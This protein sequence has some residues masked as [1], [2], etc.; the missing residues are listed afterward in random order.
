[1]P[2]DRIT[3]W[4]VTLPGL[5]IEVAF[6]RSRTALEEFCAIT[7]LDGFTFVRVLPAAT[8]TAAW[9]PRLPPYYEDIE[10]LHRA[11]RHLPAARVPHFPAVNLLPPALEAADG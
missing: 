4:I 6:W 11:W 10:V 2:R 8:E 7:A 3:S 1:M 9:P 5:M